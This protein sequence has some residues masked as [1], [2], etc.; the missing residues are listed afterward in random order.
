M[1]PDDSVYDVVDDQVVLAPT[2]AERKGVTPVVDLTANGSVRANIDVG[3]TVTFDT[4]IE[5]PPGSVDTQ[6]GRSHSRGVR[7]R[8][9]R[10]RRMGAVSVSRPTSNR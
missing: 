10:R 8:R 9:S 1:P 4:T 6:P 3:D 7:P 5:M 2:A